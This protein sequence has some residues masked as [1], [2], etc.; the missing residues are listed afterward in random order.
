MNERSKRILKAIEDSG[1]SYGELSKITKIPK[2]ALQRYATGET[3]KVPI[4][5][6][7]EIAKATNV[8]SSYLMCW[9]E[10]ERI[11][12][13]LDYVLNN[14]TLQLIVEKASNMDEKFQNR[15]LKYIDL[16]LEEQKDEDQT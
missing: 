3:Q 5:R 15:L 1:L 8:S 6:I 12:D 2:S 7:E 9:D 14:T 16:L 13:N 4:D 10:E 11:A